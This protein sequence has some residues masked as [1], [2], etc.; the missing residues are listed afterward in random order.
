MAPRIRPNILL[1]TEAD[2][3]VDYQGATIHLVGGF[4]VDAGRFAL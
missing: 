2:A 1:N 4:T 3:R